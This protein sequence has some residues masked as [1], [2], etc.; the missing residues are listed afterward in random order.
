MCGIIDWI[1]LSLLL[2]CSV[3][4]WKRKRI[5][6]YLLL[7]MSVIVI[8]SVIICPVENIWLRVG[9]AA[10]GIVFFLISKVTKEAIGYGDSWLILLLG[11]YL[12]GIR[13]LQVLFA[14][15]VLA[16]VV[17][18][19]YLWVRRF[20]RSATLPFVPFLALAFLGAMVLF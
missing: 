14:A 3:T 20:K 19:F 15:S 18:L 8:V 13:A 9:G 17:S 1:M 7:I 11:I 10:L 12:G 16:A 2:A 5:P 6:L 4:D